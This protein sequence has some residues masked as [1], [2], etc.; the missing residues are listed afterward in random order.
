M[1][2]PVE[3]VHSEAIEIIF[4]PEQPLLPLHP[5]DP[6]NKGRVGRRRISRVNI[7][8]SAGLVA[9]SA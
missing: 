7:K 4:T 6:R 1:W 8:E 9:I 5:H 2:E 3:E